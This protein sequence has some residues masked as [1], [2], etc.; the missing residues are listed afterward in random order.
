MYLFSQVFFP[1][2]HSFLIS[3]WSVLVTTYFFADV[4]REYAI[5][6]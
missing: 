4:W 5:V 3:L 2:F 6:M 1:Q